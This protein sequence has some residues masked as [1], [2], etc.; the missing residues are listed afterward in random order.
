MNDSIV[1]DPHRLSSAREDFLTTVLTRVQRF[2]RGR[3]WYVVGGL[4]RDRQ[5]KRSAPSRN[6]DLAV[7]AEALARS[8][9]LAAA[10]G[11]AYVP[12]DETNG[13][14]RIVV[15]AEGQR[16]ALDV[17]QFRGATLEEDLARRDFTCNAMAVRLDDWLSRPDDPAVLIDPLRG[18][19]ALAERRLSPCCPGT[20]DEDPVRILRAFRFMAQ[21]GF[22]LDPAMT[23][24]MAAACPRLASVSGERVRDE[25]VATCE[26]DHA[27]PAWRALNALGALDLL[28]PELIP[29]RGMD[30]GGYHHLDVLDHQLE[31]VAQA[32]R[33]LSDFAEF[34]PALQEP[35]RRYCAEEVVEGRSRK[36]LI[37]LAG[38]LHDVGKPARRTVEAD[39]EIW[40]LGHEE[41]GAELVSLIAERL[42]L[43]NR[44]ADLVRALVRHHL[45][46][47]FLSREPQLTR[48]AVY[49]F[50]KT[51]GEHGPACLFVWWADRMAT[52]GPRSRLDQ[53]DQQRAFLEQL[54]TAYFFQAE[55]VVAPP[56]LLDGRRIMATFQLSPGPL[57][58]A[59]L[60]AVEEAQA[61]GRVRSEEDALE[62]VRETLAHP[63]SG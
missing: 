10:L 18:R 30:Q 40:F 58:G 37:K 56:K 38:L 9:E 8:R 7:G 11:G 49:R 41:T 48:R 29:G 4:V 12:L 61:E 31:T 6:A 33:L 52:R 50:F 46:P 28:L 57:I 25:L 63:P 16:V 21:F 51:L 2:A 39:G 42:R 24:V 3:P 27:A 43:A 34:S 59:L 22:T 36:A 15:T 32:D 14:A 44:E 26:T 13:S 20:F 1:P 47:G 60:R 23:P 53:L 62:L 54:F 17:S 5:L 45:R 35:M 19:Q 55:E